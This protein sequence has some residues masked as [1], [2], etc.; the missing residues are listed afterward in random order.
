MRARP[1]RWSRIV[2]AIAMLLAP[3][4]EVSAAGDPSLAYETVE[5]SRIT[6]GQTAI[7][8]VT[9]LDG[10]LRNVPLPTVPGLT[11]EVLGRT[12]GLEFVGGHSTPAWYV[13]IR[14][15]PKFVGVFSI[16]GLTAKSPTVGL[17][18][19]TADAPNPYAW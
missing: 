4:A 13:I 9:S 18:V 10:Y 5:P 3:I 8:R 15:T 16:P 17:E 6:L 11:F 14:V 12:E 2:V 19:V 1:T 7:I